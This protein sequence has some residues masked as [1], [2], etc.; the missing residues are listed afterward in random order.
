M[1]VFIVSQVLVAFALIIE[2][3]AM[4]MKRKPHLLVL[5]SLSCLFNS[6]HYFLLEQATAGFIFLLSSVRFLVN[7]R[8]QNPRLAAAFLSI[9]FGI[10]VFTYTG[11]LSLLGLCATIFITLSGFCKDKTMRV[12]MIIGGTVWLVHNVI[13]MSPIAI[14]LELC[15][16]VSGVIGFYRHYFLN[17]ACPSKKT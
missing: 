6:F 17:S 9:S 10:T 13:L 16:V 14:I 5:L 12:L 2:A 15:F 4:Q 11:L 1:S 3:T 8:W 7:L